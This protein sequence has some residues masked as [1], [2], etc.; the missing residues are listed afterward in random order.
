M[1]TCL[2]RISE[3]T[4]GCSFV[5]EGLEVGTRCPVKYE[6]LRSTFR[7]LIPCATNSSNAR[8]IDLLANPEIRFY[9]EGLSEQSGGK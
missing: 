1:W 9:S 5:L 7:S 8:A 2:M 3:S 4:I 6:R